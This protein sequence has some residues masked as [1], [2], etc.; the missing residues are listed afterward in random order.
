ME[1]YYYLIISRLLQLVSRLRD[2]PED[3]DR[4]KVCLG[5]LFFICLEFVFCLLLVDYKCQLFLMIS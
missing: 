3:L 2:N 5:G 4:A 1:C